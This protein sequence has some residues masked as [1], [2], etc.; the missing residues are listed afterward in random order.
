MASTTT[1]ARIRASRSNLPC[2]RRSLRRRR[3]FR[4]LLEAH[5]AKRISRSRAP[6]TIT[7][8]YAVN[9][10]YRL[11]YVQ[12]RNLDI[13]QQ[14]RPTLL[15][16][17][18]YTGTKGTDLDILEA[19]NRTP[20]GSVL[21]GLTPSPT[22]TPWRIRRRTRD[23]CGC[24]SGWREASRSAAST[25]FPSRWTM[26]LPLARERPRWRVLLD[27]E[28][29]A[30]APEAEAALRRAEVRPMLRRIL[31]IY[32]RSAGFPA[33]TRRI[34]SPRIIC[35]SCPLATTS[36][37]SRE[38]RSA[39]RDCRRLAMERRLDD[40]IGTA[41]YAA[42]AERH[43]SDVNGGTNGTLRPNLVPGNR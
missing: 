34:S 12:I 9:P 19:P 26:H 32:P 23:R 30:R 28:R 22:K 31:S 43:V 6:G 41:V 14:I 16:N 20:T 33:S 27:W 1:P 8:N 39:A 38:I 15:L 40:R 17:L 4:R 25:P 11:G 2:S 18:D 36:A 24:A 7:N 13:Q 29:A 10:N 35:G 42:L 37:G 5:A 3:M 21:T